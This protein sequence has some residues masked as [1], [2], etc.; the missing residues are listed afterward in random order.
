M[1]RA[2]VLSCTFVL[3]R[4]R[5]KGD[6]FPSISSRKLNSPSH[7]SIDG[8]NGA[9]RALMAPERDGAD[10]TAPQIVMYSF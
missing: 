2:L 6:L 5:K 3:R 8:A 9:R 7:M 1:E 4:F 10:L